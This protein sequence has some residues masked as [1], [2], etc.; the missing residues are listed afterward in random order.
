MGGTS[1]CVLVL[2]PFGWHSLGG[3]GLTGDAL[4]H[5]MMFDLSVLDMELV[6]SVLVDLSRKPREERV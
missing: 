2:R 6:L 5:S 1:W 4:I 3:K